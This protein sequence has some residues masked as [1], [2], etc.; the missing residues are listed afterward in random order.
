MLVTGPRNQGTGANEYQ[1][2]PQTGTATDEVVFNRNTPGAN[3]L[4]WRRT[5]I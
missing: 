3:I 5:D 2:S 4:I 1:V